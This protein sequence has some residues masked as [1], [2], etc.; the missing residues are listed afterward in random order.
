M[1]ALF[2]KPSTFYHPLPFPLVLRLYHFPKMTQHCQG[3]K[4]HCPGRGRTSPAPHTCPYK[5]AQMKKPIDPRSWCSFQIPVRIHPPHW[6]HYLLWLSNWR[7]HNSVPMGLIRKTCPKGSVI[8]QG[9]KKS[10][11]QMTYSASCV[12]TRCYQLII[13]TLPLWVENEKTV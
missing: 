1:A 4:H 2:C 7:E 3:W 10:K 6:F 9:R 5:H 13:P 11:R 8:K 12:A